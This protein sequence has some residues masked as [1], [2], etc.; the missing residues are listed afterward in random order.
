VL[1]GAA[2]AVGAA[3]CAVARGQRLTAIE[4]GGGLTTVAARHTFG[5][6]EVGVGYR[7]G[8]GGGQ[9]RVS[10]AVAAGAEDGRAAARALLTVQFLVTPAARG[11]AGLYG[12]LGAAV[13]G[14]RGSPGGGYLALLL[15]LEGTPGRR[16]GW[17]GELGLCG[18]VRAAVG[19]R[20]RRFPAWW[21][22]GEGP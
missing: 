13:T 8:G 6:G 18:G 16:S 5:A 9:T 14:R 4:V 3:P 19:W 12:G 21:R 15:G 20:A 11:G 7:G 2:L 22:G 17:Y 10:L 1:L